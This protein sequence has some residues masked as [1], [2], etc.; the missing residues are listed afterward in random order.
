[1]G[2]RKGALMSRRGMRKA[3]RLFKSKAWA[4][5]WVVWRFVVF[6]PTSI[7]WKGRGAGVCG[8]VDLEM[9][10]LPHII[11]SQTPSIHQ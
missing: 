7:A 2:I 8:G 1:M 3:G 9:S 4:V 10:M 11:G 6:N 5:C